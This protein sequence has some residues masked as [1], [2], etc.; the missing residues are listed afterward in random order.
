MRGRI[1]VWVAAVFVAGCVVQTDAIEGHP[2]EAGPPGPEGGVGPQGPPGDAGPQ[3]TSLFSYTDATKTDIYYSGGKVGIGTM[4]P[5][6]RVHV[7]GAGA[8]VNVIS[9]NNQA[10]GTANFK[11]V[12]PADGLAEVQFSDGS[13]RGSDPSTSSVRAYCSYSARHDVHE[14][15]CPSSHSRSAC[16]VSSSQ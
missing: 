8:E 16:V 11:A 10:G 6:D 5:A 2:G 14:E 1:G 7:V 3:G 13:T 9:E 4:T 15:K 12:A